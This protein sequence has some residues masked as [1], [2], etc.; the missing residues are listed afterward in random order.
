M[1]CKTKITAQV[2]LLCAAPVVM[3]AQ[4]DFKMDG[5]KF[6]VHS[7]A[8]QG[9]AYSNDNNYLTMNTSQGSFAMT[10]GGVNLS[11]QI[12]DKFRVGAQAYDRNVGVM[13]KGRVTL[14][15]ALGDYKFKSW[16]GVRAGKVKTVFG[17]YNDTQDIE[18]LHTWAILPQSA[19]PIDLRAST[20]AHVG[21]DIYG[22]FDLQ[23]RGGI[24]YTAYYG[25]RPDD[26]TGGY[27]YGLKA[28]GVNLNGVTGTQAGGD[29]R[30]NNLIKDVTFGASYM[31]S[32]MD[33]AGTMQMSPL[34]KSP[35]TIHAEDR[36][37]AY[38]V[39]YK[40]GSLS[41]DGEYRLEKIYSTMKIA[42]MPTMVVTSL[43]NPVEC[44]WYAAA[45]YRI[46]KRLEFGTYRSWFYPTW[47]GDRDAPISHITDQV[48]T[49]RVDLA[50][51]WDVKIEGH[52]MDG[53]G[54][55]Q[56]LR[57]FYLQDNP[58]GLQPKTNMLV[59]R[60]GWNF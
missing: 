26:P 7:F 1:N 30:W 19:Y 25:T 21:G 38:Y 58:A 52:F 17:L 27:T 49:A 41:V 42:V 46:S 5:L 59:I 54:N 23:K 37:I 48:V 44:G 20:I 13:G 34:P 28:F 56:S 16:F 60:T 53:Y 50:K 22:T 47:T 33:T 18:S 10:D 8:S 9:F 36:S 11:S 3:H 32:P 31:N 24:S 45:A 12:T 29:L 39:S 40:S 57:G 43:Y 2:A 51:F 35:G 4:F 14:D 55:P 6:Q 15:W